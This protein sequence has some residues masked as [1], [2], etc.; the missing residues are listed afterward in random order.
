MELLIS[1]LI[2]L[3]AITSGDGYT[4]KQIEDIRVEKHTQLVDKYGDEYLSILGTDDSD[5]KD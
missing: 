1:F 2:A 4:S 5:N 3:G